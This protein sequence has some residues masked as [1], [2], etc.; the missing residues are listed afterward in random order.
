MQNP[1]TFFMI[2]KSVQSSQVKAT[3]VGSL[4]YEATT[5]KYYAI[6]EMSD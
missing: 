4:S 3:L 5:G 2:L 1:Q 6:F